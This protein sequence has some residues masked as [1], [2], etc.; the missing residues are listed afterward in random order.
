MGRY[1]LRRRLLNWLSF[2]TVRWL[3]HVQHYEAELILRQC[4]RAGADVHLRMP[5]RIYA[6]ERLTLGNSVDIGEF[7]HIR[8]NGGVTIGDRVLIASH[9]VIATRGHPAQ[10]PRYGVTEDAPIRIEDDVWIGAGAILLPGV[11]VGRGAIVAAGAVV[12]RDVPAACMVAGVPA[13][14]IKSLEGESP[15]DS[16]E[17]NGAAAGGGA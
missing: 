14:V 6:P 13:K 17:A 16:G 5:V 2:R 10:L 11:T 8:A 4:A 9:V 15:A 3:R 7:S 12:T 1:P